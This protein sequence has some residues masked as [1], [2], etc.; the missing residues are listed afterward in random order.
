MTE[1][2]KRPYARLWR[3]VPGSLAFLLLI[4]PPAIAVMI[5]AITGISAGAGLLITF[6]G[7]PVLWATLWIVRGAAAASTRLTA[8]TGA[9]P[10]PAS[11]WGRTPSGAGWIRAMVTPLR[12]PRYW[13]ALVHQMIVQPVV[14]TATFVVIAVWVPLAAGGLTSFAWRPFVE[15]RPEDRMF[16]SIEM[17][18]DTGLIWVAEAAIYLAIGIVAT[19]TL[20]WVVRGCVALHVWPMRWMLGRWDSD[21]L[22]ADLRAEA[23]ARDAA[24]RA[25][26]LALR[27]LERDL[28]DGP[29]QGLIRIQMDLDVL[30]RRISRGETAGAEELA[31]ETRAR[32]QAVLD[33]LR[34]L[35][36]GVAPPLLA[37]RGLAAALTALAATAPIPVAVRLAP[38][39]DSALAPEVARTVY[40]TI[41]ELL[42]NIAKHADAR[43]AGLQA[44]LPGDPPARAEMIVTDDG[45]GGAVPV[46]GHGLDGLDQRLRGVRGRLHIDSPPGGPTRI[47]VAVPTADDRGAAP[48]RPRH[49]R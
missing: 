47:R 30:G 14:A 43:T 9:A 33:E 12:T 1:T 40:F 38:G 44:D 20:P 49:D 6:L 5:V 28:H 29:Q 39:L 25:E 2:T 22:R 8:L 37:D 3:A 23:A 34:A 7:F 45:V 31:A 27:R 18:F 16:G 35:S 24:V 26:D 17:P 48:D 11:D 32:T 41:A 4:W 19:V 15:Q 42:T 13:V 10:I 36:A 46:P 21:E